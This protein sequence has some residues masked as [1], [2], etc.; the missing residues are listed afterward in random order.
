MVHSYSR[1]QIYAISSLL[2]CFVAT[3]CMTVRL[4]ADYDERIDD[5]VTAFQQS[6][7]SHLLGLE[8]RIATPE[9]DY[10]NY[11]DFYR[12]AKV[13]LSSLRVR[14]EAQTQNAITVE[15]IELLRA[16]V[17]LLQRMHQEGLQK[18]DIPPLR[19]A[20]NSG[21]TAILRLELAKKR[22]GDS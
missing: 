6:M 19:A 1:R 2:L 18:N 12:Q 7:E 16:N 20:F 10:D 8:S 9:G 13:D 15:Q 11:V 3:G 4:V 14:A 21:A 22:G 5:G 17:E